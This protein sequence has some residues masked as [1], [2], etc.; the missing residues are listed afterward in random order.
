MPSLRCAAL[1]VSALLA[2]GCA[3][4]RGQ[5]LVEAP[6]SAEADSE[7]ALA[8][9]AAAAGDLDEGVRARALGALVRSSPEPA[10]GAWAPRGLYDP[11]PWVQRA[12]LDAL[13]SRRADAASRQVLHQT[14][15][16][17]DLDPYVRCAAAAAL[18][19]APPSGLLETVRRAETEAGA[20]WRAAP[21]ALAAAQLDDAEAEDRLALILAEGDLPFN[22]RFLRDVGDAGFTGLVPALI[23]ASSLV[24]DALVPA[25]GATLLQ[26]GSARGEALLKDGLASKDP[27]RQLESLDA[28]SA[29]D[30]PSATAALRRAAVTT[31]GD[32]RTCA[33]LILSGREDL[34]LDLAVEA[35]NGDD[36]ELRAFALQHTGRGL[37]RLRAHAEDP[38]AVRRAQRAALELFLQ[39]ADD[40]ESPVREAA[41]EALGSLPLPAAQDRLGGLLLDE[42]ARVRVAAALSLLPSGHTERSLVSPVPHP[43]PDAPPGAAPETP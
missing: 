30:T 28:L 37:V 17:T 20:P 3:H 16:R 10:G 43:A 31:S 25:I 12:T 2:S 21:C 32:T 4:R 29:V 11:S 15:Q 40:P 1:L 19:V 26:L 13:S 42:S 8:V 35:T 5:S 6:R 7:P 38:R 33:R 18:H 39:G 27:M 22:L 34:D 14:A 36:R 23:E 41:A 24:E 9:L